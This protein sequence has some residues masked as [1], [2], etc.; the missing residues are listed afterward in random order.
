MKDFIGQSIFFNKYIAREI[1]ETYQL[2]ENE[3]TQRP[4]TVYLLTWVPI[5][6]VKKLWPNVKILC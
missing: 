1:K 4:I 3:E 6:S 2:K 5:Q